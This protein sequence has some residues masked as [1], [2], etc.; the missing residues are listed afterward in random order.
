MSFDGRMLSNVNVLAAIV[1]CGSFAR[2]AAA[3]DRYPDLSLELV[4]REQLGDLVA[5]G[6]DIA[7]RFGQPPVSSLIAR[8]LLE[9]QTVTI[10]TPAYLRKHGRPET[11]ADLVD[12]ACI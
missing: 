5:E 11:P 6:F 2:A 4:P 8:K 7:V 12:H 3:L 1:E 10:A 9:T